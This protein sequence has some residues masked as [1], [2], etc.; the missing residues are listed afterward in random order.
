MH[1]IY[2]V[3]ETRHRIPIRKD[4][5]HR[6]QYRSC[7]QNRGRRVLRETVNQFMNEGLSTEIWWECET[8]RIHCISSHGW[9]FYWLTWVRWVVFVCGKQSYGKFLLSSSARNWF[10]PVTECTNQPMQC[11]DFNS[12]LNECSLDWIKTHLIKIHF[13]NLYWKN[14]ESFVLLSEMLPLSFMYIL[15]VYSLLNFSFFIWLFGLG[16]AMLCLE[17]HHWF[18]SWLVYIFFIKYFCMQGGA[19]GASCISRQPPNLFS[20]QVLHVLAPHTFDTTWLS[21]VSP[22]DSGQFRLSDQKI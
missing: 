12:I 5:N 6:E 1:Y 18:G 4:E 21:K 2:R 8:M 13:L 19:R 11:R 14:I 7:W 15:I 16:K 9:G 17:A 22:A 10:P 3:V 20:P